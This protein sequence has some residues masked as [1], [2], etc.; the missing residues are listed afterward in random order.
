MM[1]RTELSAMLERQRRECGLGPTSLFLHEHVYSKHKDEID[2]WLT[3]NG[4]KLNVVSSAGRQG[5]KVAQWKR[6]RKG[7]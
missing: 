3:E 5:K 4:C 7:R 1:L 6:E 2:A